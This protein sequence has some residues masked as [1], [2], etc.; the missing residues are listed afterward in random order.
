MEDGFCD[1]GVECWARSVQPIVN[2]HFRLDVNVYTLQLV[3]ATVQATKIRAK[4]FVA[5]V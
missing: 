4:K 3:I 1:R 5:V 2:I